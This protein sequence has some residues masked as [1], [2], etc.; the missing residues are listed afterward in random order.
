MIFDRSLADAE[1]GGDVLAR[2]TSENEVQN[3]ALSMRQASNAPRGSFL[4]WNE[5]GHFALLIDGAPNA[6]QQLVAAHRLF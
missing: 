6:G 4:S 1:I 3:L 5:F 2:M